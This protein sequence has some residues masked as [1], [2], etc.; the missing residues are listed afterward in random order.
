VPVTITDLREI[1]VAHPDAAKWWIGDWLNEGAARYGLGTEE[2]IAIAS[3]EATAIRSDR[4]DPATI[5]I[6][7]GVRPDSISLGPTPEL[8][9]SDWER[10]GGIVVVLHDQAEVRERTLTAR[11]KFG[12]VFPADQIL[13]EWL[14]AISMAANDL[15][16]VH[17]NL[18]DADEVSVRWY[19]LRASAGHYYEAAQHLNRTAE[20]PA[21]K[22]FVASLPE[23]ARDSYERTLELFRS[24]EPQISKMRQ[25]AFH[26]PQIVNPRQSGALLAARPLIDVL[27]QGQNY[28]TSMR[29]GKVRESRLTYADELTIGLVARQVGGPTNLERLNETIAE[30]VEALMRFINPALEEHFLRMGQAGA[31]VTYE[32][33][34]DPDAEED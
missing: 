32:L 34:P 12:E 17:S 9:R 6:P 28:D 21:I 16:T 18:A 4:A 33:G 11:F 27:K 29:L 14:A 7:H 8:S 1:I 23:A 24:N 19:Y 13:S 15:I 10:L 3:A 26:Y 5:V 20:E 22:A 25:Y 2:A 31:K 30:A